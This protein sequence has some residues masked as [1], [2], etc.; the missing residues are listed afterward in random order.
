MQSIKSVMYTDRKNRRDIFKEL[1]EQGK[2]TVPPFTLRQICL[3][4]TAFLWRPM[5]E[6][7]DLISSLHL[8]I[9][10]FCQRTLRHIHGGYC[11]LASEHYCKINCESVT[12]PRSLREKS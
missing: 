8:Y 1:P 2:Y 6:K 11:I 3:R 7:L 5:R 10:L 12:G 9:P 4:Q